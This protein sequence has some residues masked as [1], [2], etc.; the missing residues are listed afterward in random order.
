MTTPEDVYPGPLRRFLAAVAQDPKVLDKWWP[1]GPGGA[2]GPSKG[3]Y[4]D[5]W[6]A[7]SDDQRTVLESGTLDQIA[8]AVHEEATKFPK[9]GDEVDSAHGLA[10]ALVRV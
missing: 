8:A 3:K 9:L 2:D 1:E 4:A 10:W 6:K 5:L 7:L